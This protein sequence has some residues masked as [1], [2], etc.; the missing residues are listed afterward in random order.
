MKNKGVLKQWLVSYVLILILPVLFSLLVYFNAYKSIEEISYNYNNKILFDVTDRVT[1]EIIDIQRIHNSVMIDSVLFGL[2]N[3][4]Y[5][6]ADIYYNLNS[7]KKQLQ[8]MSNSAHTYLYIYF[9]KNGYCVSN[10][11][12][13]KF[14]SFYST[15]FNEKYSYKEF[16]SL[17]KSLGNNEMHI[18]NDN[19]GNVVLLQNIVYNSAPVDGVYTYFI[20]YKELFDSMLNEIESVGNSVLLIKSDKGEVVY[21]NKE[22][23]TLEL[24][25]DKF[26]EYS[27]R[28]GKLSLTY[29]ADK[30]VHHAPV[31]SILRI[32]II[33]IILILLVGSILVYALLYKNYMPIKQLINNFSL[34]SDNDNDEFTLI[35][36]VFD[37][38]TKEKK[39]LMEVLNSNSDIIKSNLLYNLL[40]GKRVD[41]SVRSSFNYYNIF[42]ENSSFIVVKCSITDFGIL[43]EDEYW[44]QYDDSF[45]VHSGNYS[46]FNIL[47]ELL[48]QQ[49][50][51]AFSTEIDDYLVCIVSDSNNSNILDTVK[52]CLYKVE[53][54]MLEYFNISFVAGISS[55]KKGDN[56]VNAAYI[57]SQEALEYCDFKDKHVVAFDDMVKI[58]TNSGHSFAF[59]NKFELEMVI[60]TG[61]FALANK[62]LDMYLS[63]YIDDPE[64]SVNTAKLYI[65]DMIIN[66]LKIYSEHVNDSDTEDILSNFTQ[67][68]STSTISEMI[69]ELRKT[70]QILCSFYDQKK[71]NTRIEE[72]HNYIDEHYCDYD[73]N[74]NKIGEMFDFAPSYISKMFKQSFSEDIST[75]IMTLRIAKS[76]EL[77]LHTNKTV[78]EIAEIVGIY[79][80]V[81]FTRN[82]K[83]ITKTT[84]GAYRRENGIL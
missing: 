82:F 56:D 71:P 68:I 43:S 70:L 74:I 45:I 76:K 34:K 42:D 50:L 22:Y 17:L 20:I 75:Y 30:A 77:L 29:Y 35:G 65:Y 6:G 59:E 63:E 79:N 10:M 3:N 84:P 72:I 58:Q 40:M 31:N 81:T 49:N 32:I 9:E 61:D 80:K 66:V 62:R 36:N 41:K 4:D 33:N 51:I 28:A 44:D 23:E 46:V 14:D 67:T 69:A 47:C 27:R 60:K 24:N 21:C 64:V 26:I 19:E 11:T 7:A 18:L 25:D 53:E 2:I 37:S 73:L 38:I 55:I 57:E 15:K 13:D 5:Y 8:I 48:T 12:F 78:E 16:L 39:S 52:G 83:K 54:Y 1:S